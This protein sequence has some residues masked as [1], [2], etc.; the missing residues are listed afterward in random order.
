MRFDFFLPPYRRVSFVLSMDFRR[1]SF[2]FHEQIGQFRFDLSASLVGDHHLPV[3]RRQTDHEC[4]CR[5]P[6][7]TFTG[8]YF[9][10]RHWLGLLGHGQFERLTANHDPEHN[11]F[12]DLERPASFRGGP[13][14]SIVA[15]IPRSK[16]S[17]L[18]DI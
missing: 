9:D 16:R 7:T 3:S 4:P 11:A 18:T 15:L 5:P 14:N 13:Q 12:A 10:L 6:W 1:E 17:G 2:G 8:T